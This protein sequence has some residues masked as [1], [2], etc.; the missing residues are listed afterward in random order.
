MCET[1]LHSLEQKILSGEFDFVVFSEKR[2]CF[3]VV[4]PETGT[5]YGSVK[6][7]NPVLK[8]IFYSNYTYNYKTMITPEKFKK[9]K[10][11]NEKPDNIG[12][13]LGPISRGSI[14]HDQIRLWAESIKR[15]D[16]TIYYNTHAY[17]DPMTKYF[18]TWMK[19]RNFKPVV[20]EL[21]IC[22]PS[23]KLGT[24][25]DMIASDEH[26]DLYLIEIKTGNIKTFNSYNG[27][28]ESVLCNLDNSPYNQGRLQLITTY[29]IL[30]RIYSV[31]IKK[32]ILVHISE[33]GVNESI[34]KENVLSFSNKVY[35]VICD[36][37]LSSTNKK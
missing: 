20:C 14:V 29:Q 24:A 37:L 32:C 30:K 31:N 17:V 34:I 5:E 9:I 26:G 21:P 4:D 2:K 27:F 23:I 28:M 35:D 8:T 13:K 19:V 7:V 12:V 3:V 11:M 36:E 1:P 25:C 16:P 33:D 18:F 22:D 10:T 15:N 6:G